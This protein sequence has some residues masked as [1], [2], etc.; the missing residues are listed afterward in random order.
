MKKN[1][2]TKKLSK[3]LDKQEKTARKMEREFQ[4]RHET[5]LDT[6]QGLR[7]LAQAK[8]LLDVAA[9]DRMIDETQKATMP[10]AEAAS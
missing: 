10:V 1:K 8:I 9:L 4:I 7:Q 3:K 5:R 6:L 2:T